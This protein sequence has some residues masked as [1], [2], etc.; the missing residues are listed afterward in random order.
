M[1]FVAIINETNLKIEGTDEMTTRW[2][3]NFGSKTHKRVR[4]GEHMAQRLTDLKQEASTPACRATLSAEL[5]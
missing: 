2:M 3:K 4:S 1:L 5:S